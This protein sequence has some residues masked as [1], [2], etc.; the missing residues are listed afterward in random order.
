M[1][2]PGDEIGYACAGGGGYGDPLDRDPESVSYTHLDQM[3]ARYNPET[4]TYGYNTLPD[5][6]E[7]FFIP[8]P[9]LRCV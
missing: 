9:A 7:V 8:N 4:L 2:Y 1:L 5:G 3:A 6:E